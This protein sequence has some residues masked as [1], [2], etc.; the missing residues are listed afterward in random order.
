MDTILFEYAIVLE[1]FVYGGGG[2]MYDDG[3]YEGE[4]VIRYSRDQRWEWVQ[5]S[6]RG[7]VGRIFNP[8][9]RIHIRRDGR[10]NQFQCSGIEKLGGTGL[11]EVVALGML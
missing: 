7:C 5:S 3:D 10:L 9:R 2:P 1:D 11:L 4:A 6:F 8:R